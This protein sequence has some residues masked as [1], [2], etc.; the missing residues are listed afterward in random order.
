[1]TK[2]DLE[3]YEKISDEKGLADKRCTY[4]DPYKCFRYW[5]SLSALGVIKYDDDDD[6]KHLYDYWNNEEILNLPRPIVTF[7]DFKG[8]QVPQQCINMCPEAMYMYRERWL[9][10]FVDEIT[11]KIEPYIG[12][13]EHGY[14]CYDE[15]DGEHY[16]SA[17]PCPFISYETYHPLHYSDCPVFKHLERKTAPPIQ[18]AVSESGSGEDNIRILT[19]QLKIRWKP[20]DEDERME[21][22]FNETQISIVK[23]FL[24]APN[25]KLKAK[26][27]LQDKLGKVLE[28]YKIS[29]Y[30]RNHP[31]W[32]KLLKH[33]G[34]GF[35]KL[36]I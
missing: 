11:Y 34:K 27:L 9:K 2:P 24:K 17:T 22:E 12:T 7:M 3:W 15:E 1:M 19:E 21:D 8:K 32:R 31:T 10:L 35:W 33:T 29:K 26:T 28:E 25:H 16:E 18:F 23:E 30:F 14:I 4:A 6:K 20:M 5:K 13:T 36:N